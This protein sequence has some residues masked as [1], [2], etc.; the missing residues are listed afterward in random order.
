MRFVFIIYTPSENTL[1][2][3]FLLFLKSLRSLSVRNRFT[4]AVQPKAVQKRFTF[5]VYLQ[6]ALVFTHN[7]VA[8][9]IVISTVVLPPTTTPWKFPLLLYA[10]FYSVTPKFT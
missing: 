5:H 1:D 10:A 8:S 9:I 4:S 6:T 7:T 3:D 2:S